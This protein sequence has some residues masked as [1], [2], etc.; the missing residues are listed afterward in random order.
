MKPRPLHPVCEARLPGEHERL[1]QGLHLPMHPLAAVG[2]SVVDHGHGHLAQAA[3]GRQV[4]GQPPP[5]G[6]PQERRDP[7]GDQQDD[8]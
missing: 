1:I 8:L 2:G 5:E 6:V 4:L 3:P 7:E